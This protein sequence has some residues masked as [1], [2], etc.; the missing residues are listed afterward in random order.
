MSKALREK[1][2][3]IKEAL[4]E[5]EKDNHTMGNSLMSQNEV[6]EVKKEAVSVVQSGCCCVVK[7]GAFRSGCPSCCTGPELRG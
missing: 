4:S 2:I 6:K 3:R 5:A 7:R 1:I